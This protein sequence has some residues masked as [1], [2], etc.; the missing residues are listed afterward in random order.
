VYR[1]VAEHLIGRRGRAS[2][3]EACRYLRKARGLVER[4]GGLS[5]WNAYLD[6]LQQR[7]QALE[8]LCKELESLKG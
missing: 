7:H 5:Q 4:T 8:G 3:A 1:A 6:Q 2:Y